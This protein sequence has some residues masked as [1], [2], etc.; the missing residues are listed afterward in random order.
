MHEE[1]KDFKVSYTRK[2]K[3][4]SN[5]IATLKKQL[6]NLTELKAEYK[7]NKIIGPYND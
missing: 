7:K 6:E 2:E 5:Q 4:L 3:K 1:L